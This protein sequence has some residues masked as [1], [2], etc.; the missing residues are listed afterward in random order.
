MYNRLSIGTVQFGLCYGIANRR[1]QVDP[2]E[3][4]AILRLAWDAGIDTLDTAMSYGVSEERLGEI[5]VKGWN[6]ITKLPAL[7]EARAG[8]PQRVRELVMGSLERL[9]ITRLSG[10]LLHR[11]ADLLGSGGVHIYETLGELK[12]QGLLQRVGISI[13]DPC[14]L[15]QLIG[16]FRF[17]LVQAP[18]NVFDRRMQSSGWLSRLRDAG[19][20]VHTRSAFL[21]GL[22]LIDSSARPRYFDRWSPLW[23]RWR[24]WLSATSTSAVDACLRFVLSHPEIARVI[25]GMDSV[26]HLQQML[27]AVRSAAPAPPPTLASDDID[28]LNPSRWPNS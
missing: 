1:G 27:A 28:L 21:Q 6:V 17:D 4:A 12:A 24:D 19:I 22:L 11:P 2:S 18:F 23:A 25:V 26:D 16:R 8:L 20:E 14:E 3:A 13:Y 15:E 5:G 10:L 9:K 7:T